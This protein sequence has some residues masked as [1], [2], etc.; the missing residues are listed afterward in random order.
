MSY[1]VSCQTDMGFMAVNYCICKRCGKKRKYHAKGYCNY[2]YKRYGTPKVICKACGELKPQYAHGL[3]GICYVRTFLDKITDYNIKKFYNISPELY[4][5]IT[6]ECF[7]CGFNSIVELHHIDGDH[8]NNN[9]N[10]LIGLCPNH[11]KM[12]HSHK[13]RKEIIEK[14]NNKQLKNG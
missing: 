5:Q 4:R 9:G 1:N 10:N 6:K 2:C 12:I 7:I 8:N 3:C 14:I 13:F 11:H